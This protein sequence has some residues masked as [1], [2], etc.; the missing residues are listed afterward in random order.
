MTRRASASP[1][2]LFLFILPSFFFLL[3]FFF[4]S[5]MCRVVPRAATGV[6]AARSR[7]VRCLCV[8]CSPCAWQTWRRSTIGSNITLH[9]IILH[10]ITDMAAI[11]H[12]LITLEQDWVIYVTDAGQARCVFRSCVRRSPRRVSIQFVGRLVVFL[13][14]SGI[15]S[16]TVARRSHRTGGGAAGVADGRCCGTL[17]SLSLLF[18]GTARV[19]PNG[20]EEDVIQKQARDSPDDERASLVTSV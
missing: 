13:S 5:L 7:R 12:R 15:F 17:S 8:L 6:C 18:L 19:D 3:L 14:F 4:F 16:L 2:I 11:H 20:D 1:F 9:Y 10:Y